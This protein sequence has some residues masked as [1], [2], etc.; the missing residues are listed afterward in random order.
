MIDP[1]K[2]NWTNIKNIINR[3]DTRSDL[4]L[5]L[6][7]EKGNISCANATMLRELDLDDPRCTSLNFFDLL[8][9]AHVDGFKKIVENAGCENGVA[10]MELYIKNGSYHP[11]KWEVNYLQQTNDRKK[12]F[13]CV[14][15]MII[16]DCRLKKFNLLL[17]KY[18]Q[19][20]MDGLTGI[21]FHDKQG[22]LIATNEQ[23]ARLFNTTL[24][25]LYELKILVHYGVQVGRSQMKKVSRLYL[26][27]LLSCGH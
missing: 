18:Q 9:P 20:I 19:L 24:E 12:V 6:I 23:A 14:G 17:E 11:M 26:K 3:R 7:D 15:Y 1:M 27:I 5:S 22:E 13:C 16:D 25:R 10:T 8:H 2:S 4:Y 21:I